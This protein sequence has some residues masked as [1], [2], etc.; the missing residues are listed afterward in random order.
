MDE[1]N[2]D[3]AYRIYVTKS[4]QLIPQSKYLTVDF[5]NLF[6]KQEVDTRS[7]DEIVSDIM[8]RAGL[9]FGD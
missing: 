2:R 8:K 3:K 4:L 5:K 9:Q 7:S 1:Y 6:E